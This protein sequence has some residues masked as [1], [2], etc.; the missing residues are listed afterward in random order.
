MSFPHHFNRL[1]SIEKGCGTGRNFDYYKPTT[2]KSVVA[3]DSVVGMVDE[4]KKKIADHTFATVSVMNAHNLEFADNSFDTVVSTFGMC[5]FEDP[6]RVLREMGR[7][8]KPEGRIL[9]LEHGKGTF[10]FINSILDSNACKHAHSWG[11][12][13]NKDIE[14]ILR[15]SEGVDVVCI[16]RWHFGTTYIIEAKP[17]KQEQNKPNAIILNCNN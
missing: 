9:L 16:S 12:I 8:C 5:S 1:N 13:W 17:K 3:V 10:S 11:C 4:A 2:V 6:E 15:T 14:N 7:V